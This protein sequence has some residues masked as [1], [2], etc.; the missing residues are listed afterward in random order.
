MATVT[1]QA[2]YEQGVLKPKTKLDLPEHS[3][4]EIDV[5]TPQLSKQTAFGALIG[6]WENLSDAEVQALEQSLLDVRRQSSLKLKKTP[7][8]RK[9]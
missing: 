5:K 6:I 7:V 9:K 4:V 1:V 3:V 2:V 8:P